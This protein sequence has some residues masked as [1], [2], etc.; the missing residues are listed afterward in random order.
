MNSTVSLKES[1]RFKEKGDLITFSPP[2]RLVEI[3][4]HHQDEALS[5][6]N[7]CQ[8]RYESRPNIDRVESRPTS[9]EP[10]VESLENMRL[11]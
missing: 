3:E 2:L 8:P 9:Q 11:V 6:S 5:A 10:E 4:E 7:S 1:P